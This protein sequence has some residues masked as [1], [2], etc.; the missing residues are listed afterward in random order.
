MTTAQRTFRRW[1]SVW[2]IRLV[3]AALWS[4]AGGILLGGCTVTARA[5]RQWLG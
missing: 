3:N 1:C 4:V 5:I 2:A